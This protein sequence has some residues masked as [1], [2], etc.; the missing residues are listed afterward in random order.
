VLDCNFENDLKREFWD[1]QTNNLYLMRHGSQ[2]II[3]SLEINLNGRIFSFNIKLQ[4]Y[5][6]I[7]NYKV[8]GEFNR[9]AI[10]MPT[11]HLHT[12]KNFGSNLHTS[13][14]SCKIIKP[15]CRGLRFF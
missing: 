12:R 1:I 15:F 11:A 3:L 8:I 2:L 4:I 7:L 6:Y 9:T 5:I 14:E 10:C 13:F